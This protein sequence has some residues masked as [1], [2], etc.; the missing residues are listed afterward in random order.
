MKDSRQQVETP[1]EFKILARFIKKKLNLD[2]FGID[3]VKGKDKFYYI[4]DIND[5]PGFR[6]VP[7]AGKL[8]AEYCLKCISI[9]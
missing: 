6:G 3:F 1:K 4:L 7:K 2:L 8:I 5:F 9:K